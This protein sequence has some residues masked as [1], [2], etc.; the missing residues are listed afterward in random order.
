MGAEFKALEAKVSGW[1]NDLRA[2]VQ[3]VKADVVAN[4]DTIAASHRKL[5][6][7]MITGSNAAAQVPWL[8]VVFPDARANKAWLKRPKYWLKEAQRV[9]V[10]E[11]QQVHVQGMQ[12]VINGRSTGEQLIIG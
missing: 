5:A 4:R 2:D 3:A 6:N 1:L 8:F 11:V 9:H 10:E 12:R 7:F